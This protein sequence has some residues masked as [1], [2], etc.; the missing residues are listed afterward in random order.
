MRTPRDLARRLSAAAIAILVVLALVFAVLAERS[1]AGR[2]RRVP[3]R[4]RSHGRLAAPPWVGAARRTHRPRGDQRTLGPSD[5]ATRTA[6]GRIPSTPRVPPPSR[7][8]VA[9]R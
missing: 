1:Y 7:E 9:D 3:V 6:G 4:P 8:R 5:A 2:A